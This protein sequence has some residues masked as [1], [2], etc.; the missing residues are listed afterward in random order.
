M[1]EQWLAG[2]DAMLERAEAR[3][4]WVGARALRWSIERVK[5]ELIREVAR[6]MAEDRMLCS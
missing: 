6:D 2:L 4:D 3:G 5:I 1:Y